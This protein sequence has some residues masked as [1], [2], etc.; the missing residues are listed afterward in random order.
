MTNPH[1]SHNL[2]QAIA[3][4]FAPCADERARM[5]REASFRQAL[6][7]SARNFTQPLPAPRGAVGPVTGGTMPKRG[8]QSPGSASQPYRFPP[9]SMPRD[10]APKVYQSVRHL[11]E[12][13]DETP[14]RQMMGSMLAALQAQDNLDAL[15]HC[16]V[17]TAQQIADALAAGRID[18]N[19][20]VV[21]PR[22]MLAQVLS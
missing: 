16:K 6:A 12:D 10:E 21:I 17:V 8:P 20:N 15:N 5:E 18:P 22:A 19:V 3:C 11:L 4:T 9:I 7:H 2:F 13:R 14:G 1:G